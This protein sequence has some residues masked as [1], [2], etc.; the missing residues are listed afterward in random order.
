M[1]PGGQPYRGLVVLALAASLAGDVLLVLPGDRFAAGLGAFLLAHVVYI[2]AFTLGVPF[3]P[4]QLVALVPWILVCG[5][6]TAFAWR[7]LGRHRAAVACYTAVIAA[8]GWRAAMRGQ[9]LAVPRASFLLAL[10]GASLFVVS[11]VVLAIRRFRFAFRGAHELELAAY[12]AAQL[13]IALSIR[14]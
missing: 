10:A 11:D 7:G 14:T 5:G 8:M 6:A 9:S 3:A 13:L 1:Q 4:P 2:A 12:W